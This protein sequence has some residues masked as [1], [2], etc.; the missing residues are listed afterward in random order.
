MFVQ[1]DISVFFSLTFI[2]IVYMSV[3]YRITDNL[4]IYSSLHHCVVCK[5]TAPLEAQKHWY[6]GKWIHS[7]YQPF[8]FFL[9][10]PFLWYPFL[11]TSCGPPLTGSCIFQTGGPT[12]GCNTPSGVSQ[13]Q[14]RGGRITSLHLLTMI[15]IMQPIQLAFWAVSLNRGLG[16]NGFQRW[17]TTPTFL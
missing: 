9:C 1:S 16:P 7:S 17:L 14:N 4:S 12:V 2:L 8:F 11:W 5:W 15:R 13:G 3:T 6:T 10:G